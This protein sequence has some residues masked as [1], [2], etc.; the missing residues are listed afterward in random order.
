MSQGWCGNTPDY[1]T[2]PD[3]QF[4]YGPGCDANKVP[5]GDDTR[6]IARPKLGNVDYGNGGLYSCTE[7]GTVAIT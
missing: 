5:N 4:D 3:C 1:C 2:S 6:K 7:P